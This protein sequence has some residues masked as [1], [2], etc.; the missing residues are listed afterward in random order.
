MNPASDMNTKKLSTL[1]SLVCCLAVAP[2]F[3]ASDAATKFDKAPMPMLTP[4]PAYPDALKGTSGM[5]S[6]VVV[7]NE[8]GTVA[9]AI[10]AKSTDAAFEAPALEA[11][12]KWKFKPAEINGQP[13]K[14]KITVPVRFSS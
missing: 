6:V 3:A 8:D 7:I 5:V 9:E 10:A 2:I 14:S 13:V 1:L 11:I 12:T 4:P